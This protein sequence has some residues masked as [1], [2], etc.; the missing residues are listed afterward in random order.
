MINRNS[1]TILKYENIQ[2]KEDLIHYK[3]VNVDLR[4]KIQDLEDENR[5]LKDKL[6]ELI[7]A[8]DKA[9]R[10]YKLGSHFPQKLLKKIKNNHIQC[11][12]KN[13]RNV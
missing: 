2:L 3:G 4:S 11:L 8:K 1:I 12:N 9:N 6:E 10:K 13:P 5:A 7:M